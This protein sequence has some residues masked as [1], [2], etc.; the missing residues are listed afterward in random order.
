MNLIIRQCPMDIP[1]FLCF[2]DAM[3]MLKV[4]LQM[5]HAMTKKL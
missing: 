3:N 1:I 4:V 2:G 5:A